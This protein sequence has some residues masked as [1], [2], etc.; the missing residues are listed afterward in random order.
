MFTLHTN[1]SVQGKVL[2]GFID[3][4]KASYI[5]I[6]T[7]KMMDMLI[8]FRKN[9]PTPSQTVIAD[10]T[11]EII[12]SYKYLGTIIDD[13]LQLEDNRNAIHSSAQQRLFLLR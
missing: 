5:K 12:S 1:E 7:S 4:C 6:T 11:D 10:D 13:K 3:W 9:P 2:D 8:D